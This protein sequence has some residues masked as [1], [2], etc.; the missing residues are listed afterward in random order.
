MAA[1]I[2]NIKWEEG[3]QREQKEDG[4]MERKLTE[5]CSPLQRSLLSGRAH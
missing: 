1:V 2:K 4:E 5:K 3:R